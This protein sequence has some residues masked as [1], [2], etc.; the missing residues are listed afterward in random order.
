M[1][2]NHAANGEMLIPHKDTSRER[3][4]RG[5]PSWLT[6]RSADMISEYI[7][8]ASTHHNITATTSTSTT[9]TSTSSPSTPTT[10]SSDPT[11]IPLSRI[12]AGDAPSTMERIYREHYTATA[13]T[14]RWCIA[15]G[16]WLAFRLR[17]APLGV[18][19]TPYH[20]RLAPHQPWSRVL[21][22]CGVAM[23][24]IVINCAYTE[25]VDW[26]RFG[27]DWIRSPRLVAALQRYIPDWKAPISTLVDLPPHPYLPLRT[28]QLMWIDYAA[29]ASSTVMWMA[30]LG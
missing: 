2:V 11:I 22:I 6:P 27:H 4:R 17:T 18:R 29:L 24:P 19:L 12:I 23:L 7:Q 26:R 16:L 20:G 5:L 25:L 14:T 13:S 28:A 30:A 3:I 21:P 15:T 1:S 10:N 9:S 8:S